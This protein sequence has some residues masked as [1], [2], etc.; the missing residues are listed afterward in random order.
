VEP[1]LKAR[2]DRLVFGVRFQIGHRSCSFFRVD[3]SPPFA[4]DSFC[5]F[6]LHFPDGTCFPN[7]RELGP[8]GAWIWG[9]ARPS[10]RLCGFLCL[11]LNR[12]GWTSARNREKR[13]PPSAPCARAGLPCFHPIAFS[14]CFGSPTK[15]MAGTKVQIC[16]P[17]LP[18]RAGWNWCNLP[19]G[20]SVILCAINN[21]GA[22]G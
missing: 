5:L 1:A 7:R 3:T 10:A 13:I 12:V 2:I 9:T 21:L 19:F 14:I 16:S 15:R 6:L 11:R 4:D 22:A 18:K 17:L 20:Y 8:G